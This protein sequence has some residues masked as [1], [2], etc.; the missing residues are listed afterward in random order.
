MIRMRVLVGFSGGV[1]SAMAATLLRDAGHDVTAVMMSLKEGE[2]GDSGEGPRFGCGENEDPDGARRLADALA[3]PLH[4]VDCRDAYRKQVLEYFRDEYMT[5]RTPNPCVK[6]NPHVK[7][8]LMPQL[9]REQGGEF[10]FFA[11][12]HYARI[13]YMEELGRHVL[14]RGVD[15]GKD[16]SYF[17]YRLSREQI[18]GTLFPLGGLTKTTV[19]AMAEERGIPVHDKPDSQD[20]YAGDYVDLLRTG[21]LEGD[22]IDSSGKILGKHN[23]YWNFTPGQ[24][25]GL[26]VAYK[27]PL[28]VIEVD[29]ESN[30]VVVGVRA[31]SLSP[32]CIV[33]DLVFHVAKPRVGEHLL[34]RLRS[35]Q[36]LRN[37]IIDSYD[38]KDGMKVRFEEPLFGVAPGQSLVLYDK[39]MVVGGGVIVKRMP[40]LST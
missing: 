15:M 37:M 38:D 20:F 39:D 1:D 25:K 3:I 8:G 22:I 29:R 14:L 30:E 34:G 21:P 33:E 18:A 2:D 16:Q 23:G 27:E 12:G 31:E 35:S 9:V 11:T 40:P 32:G 13:Q 10:D 17:L 24:R 6:C 36:P 19:R 5:G 26:R 28:Y 7:F 4:I